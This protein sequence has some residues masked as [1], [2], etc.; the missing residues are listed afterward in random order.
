VR[1][2]RGRA[3]P[4]R[5]G[6]AG[7]VRRPR[8]DAAAPAPRRTVRRVRRYGRDPP[9]P[10]L[11]ASLAA[12]E[13]PE[14]RS[15]ESAFAVRGHVDPSLGWHVFTIPCSAIRRMNAR[16]LSELGAPR[17]ARGRMHASR[18]D[19]GEPGAGR[20]GP[21]R[22]RVVDLD[23]GANALGEVLV[24]S[25]RG[26]RRHEGAGARERPA[27]DGV[28]AAAIDAVAERAVQTVR[29]LV[30]D[31]HRRRA[32]KIDRA[33]LDDE[34]TGGRDRPAVDVH[35]EPAQCGGSVVIAP[36]IVE[37]DN[38]NPA[39]SSEADRASAEGREGLGDACD[40]GGRPA[41]DDGGNRFGGAHRAIIEP[42]YCRGVTR[43]CLSGRVRVRPFSRR[44]TR[45]ERASAF[46]RGRSRVTVACRGFFTKIIGR[47][48]PD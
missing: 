17:R 7:R 21:R 5:R 36:A 1:R 18:V 13:H 35:A 24:E 16:S 39:C 23:V 10:A 40:G 29:E 15:E 25:G 19:V 38:A 9:P 11:R 8:R 30:R 32:A 26:V 2:A 3:A 4:R 44:T 48:A 28:V 14:Q 12:A 41:F 31:R 34:E 46:A 43:G 20:G 6:R 33:L 22:A 27:D 47:P 45:F 42:A 37:R